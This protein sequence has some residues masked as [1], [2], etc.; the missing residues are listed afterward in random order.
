MTRSWYYVL[1]FLKCSFFCMLR[2]SWRYP[3]TALTETMLTL[4]KAFTHNP[5]NP[6]VVLVYKSWSIPL[7]TLA[8]KKAY[9]IPTW[10][11]DI[12]HKN[13]RPGR[14]FSSF[15]RKCSPTPSLKCWTWSQR[16][17][18]RRHQ[19]PWGWWDQTIATSR[20]RRDKHAGLMRR[21]L[22]QSFEI[23]FLMDF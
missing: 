23:G 9:R 10:S 17:R 11:H 21:N 3:K 6:S 1:D 14:R 4:R 15:Q 22:V 20:W 19:T 8:M 13:F 12:P 5:H 16:R 18:H 7:K 2:S